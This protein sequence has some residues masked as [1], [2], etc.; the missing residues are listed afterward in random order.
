MSAAM[1][2]LTSCGPDLG[3]HHFV[4]ARYASELPAAVS[5][6]RN[7]PG[8]VVLTF[9]TDADLNGKDINALYASAAR[10]D[11]SGAGRMT[12]FG[13]FTDSAEPEYI[14]ERVNGAAGGRYLV[15][16][17]VTGEIWG[18][19]VKGKTPVV[20]TFDLRGS[21]KDI[22]FQLEHTGYPWATRTNSVRVDGAVLKQ[23]IGSPT[24]QSFTY[25]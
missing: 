2:G 17:P 4:S 8:Y 18:E 23:A 5:H 13:P 11:A 24:P 21:E 3:D 19:L 16:M 10:C 12:V 20:G 7:D 25:F 15:Y 14:P 1:F 9:R 6:S 22:C